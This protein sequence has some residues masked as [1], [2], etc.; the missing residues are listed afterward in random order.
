MQA[1]S[2]K[3]QP[4][5][6]GW[7]TLF[8][9]IL[10][11]FLGVGWLSDYQEKGWI[12]SYKYGH[13][14][15][16]DGLAIFICFLMVFVGGFLFIF[17]SNKIIASITTETKKIENYICPKCQTVW[18]TNKT[19][20]TICL[21]CKLSLE[22]LNGFFERHP[23][24]KEQNLTT[25]LTETKTIEITDP[26]TKES[27]TKVVLENPDYTGIQFSKSDTTFAFKSIIKVI[28]IVGGP[29]F[30]IWLSFTLYAHLTIH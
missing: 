8:T 30:L 2:D 27:T 3:E 29:F 23:D 7:P 9:G 17:G 18:P 5:S 19:N 10:S 28:L 22:A 11:F 16:Y 13:I 6:N 4:T 24:M 14:I 26:E 25:Q 12:Y 1:S 20:K 15:A 21:K